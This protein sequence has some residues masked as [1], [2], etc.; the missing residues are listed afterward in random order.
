MFRAGADGDGEGE[1]DSCAAS[2]PIRSTAKTAGGMPLMAKDSSIVTPINFREYVVA[3]FAV[4]QK[5]FVDLSVDEVVMQAIEPQQV[6]G[7]SLRRV[8][9]RG[10]GSDQKRPV[11]GLGEK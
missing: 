11:A 9:F 1:G 5:S 7:D 6:L 3:P 2:V 10:A 8:M 4:C